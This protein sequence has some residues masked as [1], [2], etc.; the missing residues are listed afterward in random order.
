MPPLT[1]WGF[2]SLTVETRASP[3]FIAMGGR[4]RSLGGADSILKR[5]T[6]KQLEDLARKLPK[7]KNAKGEEA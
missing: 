7:R 6:M 4:E 2:S 1:L 3:G 5:D